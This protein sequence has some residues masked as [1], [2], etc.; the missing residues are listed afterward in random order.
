MSLGEVKAAQPLI[1]LCKKMSDVFVV[2]TTTTQT[3][4]EEAKRASTM[5]DAVYYLPLD[6]SFSVRR[7]IRKIKPQIL[8]LVESDIWPNLLKNVKDFGSKAILVN[9]KMS[10]RSFQR[11]NLFSRVAKRVFG[12]LDLLCVQNEDYAAL[13]REIVQDPS[14]VRVTGN[15]KLDAEPKPLCVQ[16]P[17]D[18]LFL[19]IS[20]THGPEEEWIIHSLKGSPWKVFLAPRHPERFEEVARLLEK[21]KIRFVRFSAFSERKGDEEVVL[22][23]RMGQLPFCY[24]MSQLAVVGGSFVDQVGGHNI[25]EPCLY[26]CPVLFGPHMFSQKELVQKIL[27]EK[28]GLQV[29]IE[30]L[31]QGIEKVLNSRAAF[32]QRAHLLVAEARGAKEANF[33]EI[34]TFLKKN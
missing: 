3:G 23:D 12:S 11:W 27:K 16:I 17:S 9:G 6:F 29:K 19:T 21:E 10:K 33:R 30:D 32:V 13:F 1:A 26:G 7:F 18:S 22:V 34:Q 28:A 15:L 2:V 25:F 14:K 31:K 4:Q 5:A 20:C 8:F 24:A